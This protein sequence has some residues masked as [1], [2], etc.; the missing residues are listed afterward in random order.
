MCGTAAVE[1]LGLADVRRSRQQSIVGRTLLWYPTLDSTQDELRRQVSGGAEAGIVVLAETQTAGRGRRG[2]EWRDRPGQDLLFS[3]LLEAP[4]LSPGLVP[5]ALGAGLAQA[6]SALTGAP[7]EVQWPNDLVV[8]G[9]K[10]AGLLVEL[11][12]GRYLAGLGVN[13][14]GTREEVVARLRRGATTLESA[15][16]K[17]LDRMTVLG[18]CLETLE[19]VACRWP[20]GTAAQAIAERDYLY[21]KRVRIKGPGGEV[22]GRGAGVTPTGALC[23]QTEAGRIEVVVADAVKVE[24]ET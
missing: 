12:G 16:G 21:G 20:A 8:A 2:R 6:L 5:V 19:A 1:P 10:V 17:S 15:A 18:A 24:A 23:L 11:V 13:V 3:A 7:I 4:R 22:L 14:T 9:D